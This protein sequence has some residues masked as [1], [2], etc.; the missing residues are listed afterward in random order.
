MFKVNNYKLSDSRVNAIQ[1]F[2][3]L[4]FVCMLIFSKYATSMSII[5][6][7]VLG[8]YLIVTHFSIPAGVYFSRWLSI[9]KN[10]VG[11]F[12]LTL[13]FW[14][15]VFGFFNSDNTDYW[16]SRVRLRL[17]FLALPL[18]FYW[19]PWSK[20][21]K[22]IIVLAALFLIFLSSTYVFINYIL[23]FDEINQLLKTGKALPVPMKDHIRYAQL[24]AFIVLSGIY[25]LL[26]D[27]ELKKWLKITAW[28]SIA[29]IFI[30]IHVFAV[31]SGMLIL[32]AGF[33]GF[34]LLNIRRIRIPVLLLSLAVLSGIIYISVKYVPSVNQKMHYMLWEYNQ[35]KEGKQLE[36]SDSGRWLSY[37]AGLKLTSENPVFGIGPGDVEDKIKA[38]Y[39][40]HFPLAKTP[41]QPHNQFLHTL[42]GSGFVGLSFFLLM[43]TLIL[44]F[45]RDNQNQILIILVIAS[46]AS[47]MVE[48]PLETARGTALI[49]FWLSFW[50]AEGI[51][52]DQKFKIP[53]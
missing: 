30:Y 18:V 27:T 50:M 20:I 35:L 44:N 47:F 40:E 34:L 46:F 32:Y 26:N 28:F 29:A 3:G 39:A 51:P 16:L 17:P 11:F 24:Q 2:W 12:V 31:R 33:L 1:L 25:W 19:V 7:S 37:S 14:I 15:T 53:A 4:W 21:N 49:A 9:N 23:N 38:Y 36:S 48:S 22:R 8:L 5:G 41:L 6:F 52:E 13:V 10:S 45:A 43:W 42:T